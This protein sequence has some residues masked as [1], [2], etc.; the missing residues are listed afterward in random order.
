[1]VRALSPRSVGM[2]TTRL[3]YPRSRCRCFAD[4]LTVLR[5]STDSAQQLDRHKCI[6][7]CCTGSR[8][9]MLAI[10]L[11]NV[12]RI[13]ERC[14]LHSNRA[15]NYNAES[16][17]CVLKQSSSQ[18]RSGVVTCP[19]SGRQLDMAFVYYLKAFSFRH[20]TDDRHRTRPGFAMSG[21]HG[22]RQIVVPERAPAGTCC[23]VH[24]GEWLRLLMQLVLL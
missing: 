1:M 5:D 12:Q 23:D 15:R 6:H 24:E 4:K 21:R 11:C 9:V 14:A 13:D 22:S 19:E 18:E 8:E 2:W 17:A 16:D 10:T 7:T 3:V 20:R